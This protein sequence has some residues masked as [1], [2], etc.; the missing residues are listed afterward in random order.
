[1]KWRVFF[2]LATAAFLG[3]DAHVLTLEFNWWNT[4]MVIVDIVLLLLILW[5]YTEE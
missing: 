2:T 1:M 3:W 5:S 4:M